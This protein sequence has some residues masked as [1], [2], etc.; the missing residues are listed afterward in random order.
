MPELLTVQE[1]AN[2]LGV[3]RQR[4]DQLISK[5]DFAVQRTTVGNRSVKAVDRQHIDTYLSG[6]VTDRSMPKPPL[7][8]VT[9]SEAAIIL[10]VSTKSIREY[11]R[12]GH[13]AHIKT[14]N[15]LFV[16]KHGLETLVRPKRG[17][18]RKD[19]THT[20]ERNTTS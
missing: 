16:S 7:G 5:W 9:S 20:T 8:Y 18:P 2:Y 19:H 13:L 1:A 3:S 4:A 10:G 12:K 17:R 6:R 11:C 15:R 14:E